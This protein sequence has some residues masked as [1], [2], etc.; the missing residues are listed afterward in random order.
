M[1]KKT[2]IISIEQVTSGAILAL[3]G[4]AAYLLFYPFHVVTLNKP[5]VVEETKVYP[6]DF[7][8]VDLDFTKHM[9][10]APETKWIL[11]CNSAT[12]TL[13]NT[14]RNLQAGDYKNK[15]KKQIPPE[16][17]PDVCNIEIHLSYMIHPVRSP[18]IYIWESSSFEVVSREA[19]QSAQP[20]VINVQVEPEGNPDTIVVPPTVEETNVIVNTEQQSSDPQP[21]P[22]SQNQP[23]ESPQ[24]E[25]LRIPIVAPILDRILP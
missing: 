17:F 16:A 22:E 19:T 5:V 23:E 2:P 9:D 3:I 7:I 20:T 21:T 18:K 25:G 8:T 1:T 10:I 14:G 15:V 12:Y 24:P 13:T 4:Y 6:G 11:V